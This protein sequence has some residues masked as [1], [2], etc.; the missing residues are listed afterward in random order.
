MKVTLI[1]HTGAG[2]ARPDRY[3]AALLIF[4]KSTRLQMKPDLFKEIQHWSDEKHLE[5]LQYMANTIPSSWE[6]V[7][8]SF[9]VE[10]VTRAFTH[11]FVRSRHWSFAQQTMR[12]LDVS[13][14]PGWEYRTG[15]SIMNNLG[16]KSA[17]DATMYAISENYKALIASGAA[18]EDARGILPTNILTNIVGKCNT[19]GYVELTRKRKSSRTQDEYREV[20]EGMDAEV[21]RVFPWIKLFTDRTVDRA[22]QDLENEIVSMQSSF[23]GSTLHDKKIRMIKLL[24]QLRAQM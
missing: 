12:V 10:G 3:A 22:I 5:E 6:F 16:R 21:A 19:R 13:Q 4:T 20:L 17:Y 9:M 18:V 1:D 24:D 14:G 2:F 15:P 8:L 7:D 23:L 11:Q